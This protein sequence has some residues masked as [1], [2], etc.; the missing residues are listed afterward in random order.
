MKPEQLEKLARF[1]FPKAD[2]I[3]ITPETEGVE[4]IHVDYSK[5]PHGMDTIMWNPHTDLNDCALAWP[6]LVGRGLVEGYITQLVGVVLPSPSGAGLMS[7]NEWAGQLATATAPQIAAALW[8]VMVG[9]EGGEEEDPDAD[10]CPGCFVNAL[11]DDEN[12]CPPCVSEG[13]PS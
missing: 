1:Y 2:Y 6:V 7:P 5:E 12:Y 9:Q 3:I 10:M 11:G 13:I 8:Q 4:V